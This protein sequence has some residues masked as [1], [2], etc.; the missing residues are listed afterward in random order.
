MID[1]GRDLVFTAVNVHVPECG[2]PPGIQ[3]DGSSQMYHGYYCNQHGEQWVVSVDRTNRT[4]VLRGGDI[5]W[6]AEVRIN[7][8]QI[9]ADLVL[10]PDERQWLDAC[11]RAAC[12]EPLVG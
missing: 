1:K 6:A 11:W 5:G 7:N 3:D 9:D 12:G 4:G 10:G 8:G 2:T